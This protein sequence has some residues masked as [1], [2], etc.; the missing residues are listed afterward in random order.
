MITYSIAH[1][2]DLPSI[3]ELLSENTLPSIDV[4][5]YIDNF[6]VSKSDGRIIGTIG[7]EKCGSEGLLRS[8]SVS[9]DFRNKNIGKRLY[10]KLLEHALENNIKRFHLLTT[11][12]EAYFKR[13]DFEIKDRSEAPEVIKTTLEFSSLCPSSSTYMVK[14]IK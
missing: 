5:H 4:H 13:L 10:L 1:K 6:I 9:S 12:A 11:T 8:L 3:I 14:T 7:I 2:D